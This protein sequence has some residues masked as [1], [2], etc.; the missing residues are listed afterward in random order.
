[1]H[2]CQILH[3]H[4]LQDGT[5]ETPPHCHIAVVLLR[6]KL[7]LESNVT[8]VDSLLQW[9]AGH[10]W[11]KMEDKSWRNAM[12]GQI[13]S[14]IWL[15]NEGGVEVVLDHYS[16]KEQANFLKHM[17]PFRYSTGLASAEACY[18]VSNQWCT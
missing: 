13:D 2:I 10:T 15:R 4:I 11:S 1:M 14:S 18:R 12:H 7:N 17:Q 9:N 8:A 3:R 6:P 5:Q 16:T